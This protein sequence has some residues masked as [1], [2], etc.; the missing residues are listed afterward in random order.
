MSFSLSNYSCCGSAC[1]G[2]SRAGREMWGFCSEI[3]AGVPAGHPSGWDSSP[4]PPRLC[5]EQIPARVLSQERGRNPRQSFRKEPGPGVFLQRELQGLEP[6]NSPSAGTI[7]LP[8]PLAHP[9]L[10]GFLYLAFTI[11]P[12]RDC[13]PADQAFGSKSPAQDDHQLGAR[14][15]WGSRRGASTAA[16]C[17]S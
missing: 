16:C 3:P 14:G 7:L 9:K 1:G 6:P 2:F 10:C 15:I 13:V 4:C 12:K 11:F 5:V 17:A 8:Q